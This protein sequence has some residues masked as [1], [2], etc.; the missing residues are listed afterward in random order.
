MTAKI[1]RQAYVGAANALGENDASEW[2]AETPRS[3][4]AAAIAAGTLGA[5][6][7]LLNALGEP[8]VARMF[9]VAEGSAELSEAC[10]HYSAAWEECVAAALREA[11]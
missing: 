11:E 1:D 8:A 9:G 10:R 4:W 5:D 6:E 2:M 7:A 3:Q